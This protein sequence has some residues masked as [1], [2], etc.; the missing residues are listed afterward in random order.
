MIQQAHRNTALLE[1][2][3]G[4]HDL[5]QQLAR[6][7][8]DVHA[9][10]FHNTTSSPEQVRQ[11]A[12]EIV[13]SDIIRQYGGDVYRLQHHLIEQESLGRSWDEVVR[14]YALRIHNYYTTPAGRQSRRTDLTRELLVD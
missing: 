14:D 4:R 13:T 11:D 7:V 5:V 8:A 3:L 10:V 12:M 2:D 1:M 9:I 6:Q